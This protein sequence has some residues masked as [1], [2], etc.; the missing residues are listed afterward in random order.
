MFLAPS[1]VRKF[2]CNGNETTFA[3]CIR[4]VFDLLIIPQLI[5]LQ[6]GHEMRTSIC[7]SRESSFPSPGYE[8]K[9]T[10]GILGR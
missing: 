5:A 4:Y 2:L 7:G 10:L 9:N 6:Q 3:E 1:G 8:A